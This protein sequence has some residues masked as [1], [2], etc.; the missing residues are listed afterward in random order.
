MQILI[1][2][3]DRTNR[4]V[5]GK[6]CE[7]AG[8]HQITFAENGEVAVMLSS[9]HRYDLVFMDY[10]MPV[11]DG[12]VAIRAIR[13]IAQDR[14]LSPVIV[15]T[16][17]D[18]AKSTIDAG[19][20]AGADGYLSKPLSRDAVVHLIQKTARDI[21]IRRT[22]EAKGMELEAESVAAAEILRKLTGQEEL[23]K[24]DWLWV[25]G[26]PSNGIVSGDFA[27]AGTTSVGAR[28][29]FLA[30]NMGHGMAAALVN[31]ILHDVFQES[32]ALPL[33]EAHSR[34]N[35]KLKAVLPTGIYTCGALF[36]VVGTELYILNAGLPPVFAGEHVAISTELPYGIVDWVSLAEPTILP[37]D[38]G[39]WVYTDGLSDVVPVTG[40]WFEQGIRSK[41]DCGAFLD[42]LSTHDDATVLRILPLAE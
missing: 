20:K 22:Q 28:R 32:L 33:A 27:C 18:T 4:L 13:A 17:A 3:D 10:H 2:D 31:V 36:E 8:E 41:V 39:A 35:A 30:D 15:I 16:T 42:I 9:R 6:Y 26:K 12:L 14:D 5:L 23:A 11:M 40:K 34:I 19:Y 21:L 38:Q 24:L 37:L 1:V 25:S 7:L 29:G